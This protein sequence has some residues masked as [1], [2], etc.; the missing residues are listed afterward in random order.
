M[1]VQRRYFSVVAMEMLSKCFGM[2]EPSSL[3]AFIPRQT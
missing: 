3:E 2:K 1:E